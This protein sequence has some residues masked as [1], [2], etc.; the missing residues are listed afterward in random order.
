HR[1][2]LPKFVAASLFDMFSD[3]RAPMILNALLLC[4]LA[5]AMI[6]GA[7]KIRGSP[8]VVDVVFAL[9]WLSTGNAENL[10]MAFQLALILPTVLACT[11]MLVVVRRAGSEFTIAEALALVA[12]LS[13]M[14]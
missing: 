8:A 2:P 6:R 13:L 3:V 5:A 7:R 11:M 4:V 9:L 14:P 10:L 12:C 1:V